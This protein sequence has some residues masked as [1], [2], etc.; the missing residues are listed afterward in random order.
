VWRKKIKQL[1]Q[2]N[3]KVESRVQKPA[4]TASLSK[5]PPFLKT[6]TPG[7]KKD[8]RTTQGSYSLGL[9]SGHG[10]IP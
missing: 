2:K 4:A 8:S 1:L 5:P 7:V 6:S 3:L 9:S 10:Y